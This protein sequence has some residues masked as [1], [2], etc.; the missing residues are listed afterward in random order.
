MKKNQ[1]LSLNKW[2]KLD[3]PW[4]LTIQ[5]LWGMGQLWKIITLSRI[6]WESNEKNEKWTSSR[7]GA[8]MQTSPCRVFRIPIPCFLIWYSPDRVHGG[9]IR[10]VN[11]ANSVCRQN[12]IFPSDFVR[13]SSCDWSSPGCWLKKGRTMTKKW[14][15]RPLSAGCF[16]IPIL[17]F[18]LCNNPNRVHGGWIRDVNKSNSDCRQSIIVSSY[19]WRYTSCDWLSPG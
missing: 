11:K 19:S 2:S 7:G 9:W 1:R 16:R 10:D 15:C 8:T 3:H 14:E 13:Y 5:S 4:W 18:R 6:Q 12:I 17:S